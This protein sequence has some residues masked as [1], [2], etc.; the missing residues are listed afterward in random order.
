LKLP[1]AAF[2]WEPI[3]VPTSHFGQ[4]A[5][6]TALFVLAWMAALHPPAARSQ[7]LGTAQLQ[8]H[9]RDA[10][11]KL[12]VNAT[13]S[14]HLPGGG[15]MLDTMSLAIPTQIAITDGEGAYRFT[16]I[17]GGDYILK[18]TM[19]GY[20]AGIVYTVSIGH[21][22]MET[23]DVVLKP[24]KAAEAQTSAGVGSG[25]AGATAQTPEFFDEP[26]FTVAGV[27]EGSNSGGHGSDTVVRSAE[28]LAKATV[29]LGRETNKEST[30]EAGPATAASESFLRAEVA[31][32]PH[33]P[34]LHHQLAEV[35]EKLGN[36]LEAVREFERAAELD[37][38]EQFVFEWGVELLTHRALEPANEVFKKGNRLFPESVRMLIALGVADYARGDY[39]QA[40]KDLAKASDRAPNNPTPYLFL[41]KMQSVVATLP[42]ESVERLRRF[43]QL[44]PDNPLANY[45]YAVGLLRESA[46]GPSGTP[47]MEKER[48][49]RAEALLQKAVHLD[50]RFGVAYLQLGILSAQRGDY[51]GAIAAY[52][53]AIEVTPEDE[54]LENVE[55][56]EQAHYRLAQAYFRTS[57]KVKGQEELQ[58]HARLSRKA[59]DDSARERREIREFVISVRAGESE[60]SPNK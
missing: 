19:P 6:R 4:T 23:I 7:E 20:L 54:E 9:V 29:S 15:R 13:V 37:P 46:R 14:L 32:D 41:G 39:E 17:Q 3:R 18:V 5:I 44:Q 45:Y 31:R 51:A 50:P 58:I 47:E 36:P 35:E 24:T 59:K 53:K 56:L 10:S 8:G 49:A 22:A 26:Q 16:A 28:A 11:G 48:L 25:K 34:A 52:Q 30:P 55:M 43:A 1:R 40:A 60:P 27:T 21:K 38:N 42:E 33:D 12:M 2:L 57:K